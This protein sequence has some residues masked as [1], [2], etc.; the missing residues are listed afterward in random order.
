MAYVCFSVCP[1]VPANISPSG[2]AALLFWRKKTAQRHGFKGLAGFLG[3]LRPLEISGD[4]IAA[5]C[6]SVVIVGDF[7]HHLASFV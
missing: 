1:G 5:G 2:V 4:Y 7:L 6:D 3:N